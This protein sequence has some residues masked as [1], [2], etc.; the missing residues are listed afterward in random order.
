LVDS[1]KNPTFTQIKHTNPSPEKLDT[2][3]KE[4]HTTYNV[5]YHFVWIPK[6]RRQILREKNL[7]RILEEIIRG[8]AESRDWIPLAF[9]VQPD[10]IHFFVSV[11]PKVA[12]SYVMNIIKGNSSRQI[13]RIFPDLIQKYK[14]GGSLWADGFFVSTAG[15]ISEDKVKRYIDEQIKHQRMREWNEKHPRGRQ[16]KLS[17][18]FTPYPKG[19]GFSGS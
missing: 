9:E 16:G 8:Q 2:M 3:R 4:A 14:L 13:R 11:P 12:P 6:Y 15:Y 10:H 5:N 19:Q 18:P 17:P 1:M 7:K